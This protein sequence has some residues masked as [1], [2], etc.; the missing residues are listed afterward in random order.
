MRQIIR[1]SSAYY[2]LG[3]TSSL[4]QPDGKFHKIN[5]RV[6]RPG[7]EVRARP[8]YLALYGDGSRACA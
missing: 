2:L 8:G 1:D 5:V 7:L 4:N 3:Y 6:K